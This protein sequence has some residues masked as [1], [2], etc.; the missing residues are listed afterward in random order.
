MR[1]DCVLYTVYVTALFLVFTV[2]VL[3][4]CVWQRCLQEKGGARTVFSPTLSETYVLDAG[5]GGR[6]GGAVSV[7]GIPEKD[8]N[9]A[10]TMVLRD[11]L[12]FCGADVIMTREN[13]RLV[14]DETDATLKGKIKM[15]D[16]K[17]RLEIAKSFPQARF[18]SIHM[19][20]FS[21][22]KYSGLQIYYSK[23]NSES[24]ALAQATQARVREVLQPQNDRKVKAAGSNIY[25][26]DRMENPAILIEC[27]FLSNYE[28][29][30]RLT[31]REYQAQL[32]ILIAD[33]LL[34]N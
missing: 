31:Q 18:V 6:D 16:L 20:N 5:H 17:N 26:L 7:E 9:L 10:I 13:D 27:G 25:L 33:C 24:A 22:E 21:V 4:L 28:E 32:G 23:N 8:L 34:V 3:L 15:T 1:R 12:L 30:N 11:F 19:N 14:C 2:T 29:A